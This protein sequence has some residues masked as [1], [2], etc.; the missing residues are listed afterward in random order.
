MQIKFQSVTRIP[1][2]SQSSHDIGRRQGFVKASVI[3]NGA[4][5]KQGSK[6]DN[7]FIGNPNGE[8]V[9]ATSSRQ[10]GHR[11]VIADALRSRLQGQNITLNPGFFKTLGDGKIGVFEL[12]H[13]P[14]QQVSMDI[15]NREGSHVGRQTMPRMIFQRLDA[16]KAMPKDILA[17][18]QTMQ[19]KPSIFQELEE[20][21]KDSFRVI[22]R[23]KG[24]GRIT[25]SEVLPRRK[26]A[27]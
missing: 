21:H 27:N 20:E 12:P 4:S 8:I 18:V 13:S 11:G 23:M 16:L 14:Y 10:R 19:G 24:K 5:P 1:V 6:R 7:V 2:Q 25:Q 17:F 22:R 3:T 26:T 9:V 15:F